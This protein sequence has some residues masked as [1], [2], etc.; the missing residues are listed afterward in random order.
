MNSQNQKSFADTGKAPAF[1]EDLVEAILD[2][3][4]RRALGILCERHSALIS[5]DHQK[6]R[7]A[8]ISAGR[9]A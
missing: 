4:E 5:Y 1:V 7:H 9:A 6:R 8:M 3:D 2:G